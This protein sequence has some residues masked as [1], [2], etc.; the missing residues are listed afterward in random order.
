MSI[1]QEK[2]K[3]LPDAPGVY[4]FKQGR[5]VLYIGKATS[6]RDRVR[7]Y[8]SGDI[9]ESRG[10]LISKMLKEAT[11]V[12]YKETDSVLDALVLESAL[13]KKH[14]PIYNTRD[15]SDKSFNYVV[16]TKEDYPRVFTVRG[17]D[18]QAL[19]D[20]DDFKY[21]FGPFPN[22]SQLR[23]GLKIIR[24]IFPFRGE[25]DDVKKKPRKSG[26]N[27]EIGLV[28]DFEKVGKRE[29]GRTIQH[30]RLFFDGKKGKLIK[31]L[32]V[33]MKKLAKE[34][35]FES[36]EQAKRQI[37]ALEHI[38]DVSLIKEDE[39]A[40]DSIRIEAYDVAHTSGV[41]TVGVMVVMED[42]RPKKSDYRKFKLSG[43]GGDTGGLKE[44][45]ERRFK[46]DEW[47]LPRIVVVDGSKAQI[48]ATERVLEEFGYQIPVV[49]VTKNQRHQPQRVQGDRELIYKYERD[50]IIA[51]SEA[52]RFAISFHRQRRGKI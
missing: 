49:A 10:P 25:K 22:G 18:I 52:H 46:H 33:S 8:T 27:K 14:Q 43:D 7:S 21:T 16:I 41:E 23:E 31:R 13:I 26:L 39:S 42:G 28:P 24:R 17:R 30:I 1:D 34:H 5:K 3:K 4:F 12:D 2:I 15:K 38:R 44:M 9:T 6:L 50:I 40:S 20:P 48:N 37:F 32:A 51:N 47:Q 11:T 35:K 36:A 45:L 29:Y 19:Y